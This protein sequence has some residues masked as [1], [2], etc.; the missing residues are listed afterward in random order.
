MT[1]SPRRNIFEMKRSLLT[2]LEPFCPLPVLGIC[3]HHKACSTQAQPRSACLLNVH[4][5]AVH[6][7]P[8]MHARAWYEESKGAPVFADRTSVHISVTFSMIMLQCLSK[9]L[10]RPSSL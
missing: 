10:T 9:A 7:W 6:A 5:A 2:G 4:C 3:M 1:E 8:C